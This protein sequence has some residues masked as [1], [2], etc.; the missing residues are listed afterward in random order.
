MFNKQN[1]F[2]STQK[3]INI[4]FK[5]SLITLFLLVFSLTAMTQTR[6]ITGVVIDKEE[7]LPLIGV[8]VLEQGTGRGTL[9]DFDGSYTIELE[10][11][12]A[13]LNF[14][15]TG[16]KE[17]KIIVTDQS[18]IDIVMSTDV[19]LLEEVVVIGYGTVKKSDL[20]GAV[21]KVT[22]ED[23]N[24]GVLSSPDQLIQGRA[25]GVQVIS[26]SGQPGG[27]NTVRIRGNNSIRTGNDPLYVVDG[28]QITATSGKPGASNFGISSSPPSNPLSYLNPSDIA[29]VEI[30]KDASATAIYGSRGANGVIIITT[31]RGKAGQPT[32]EVNSSLGMSKLLNEPDHLNASEYREA[33]IAYD[34]PQGDFGAEIDPI[35]A[36]TRDAAIT[37]NHSISFGNATDKGSFRVSLGYFDQEGIIKNSSLNRMNANIS[38]SY[39]FLQSEKLG[40]DVNLV[41]SNIREETPPIGQT[42]G[43]GGSLISAALAWNPTLDF[44]DENGSIFQLG[45]GQLA[46]PIALLEGFADNSKQTNIISKVSPSY[47]ITNDLTYR[48]DYAIN[49][50]NGSRRGYGQRWVN[51]GDNKGRGFAYVNTLDQTTTILTHTLNYNKDISEQL[52]INVLGGFEWQ[53]SV[54]EFNNLSARDFP[55]DDADYTGYIA[56]TPITSRAASSGISPTEELQSF[57]GRANFNFK[58][59]YLLTATFRAD[60]S[61]KF[62]ENN[63]YGYFPSA[64][65]AWNLSN[66]QF[67]ENTLFSNLKLRLSWGQTGNQSFPA[68]AAGERWRLANDGNG[69]ALQ[70]AANPFLKWE[71]TTSTNIGVDVGVLEDRI[72][73]SVEYFNNNTADLLFETQ[74]IFPGPEDS[75]V[76][77]NL[78]DATVINKGVEVTLDANIVSKRRFSWNIGANASF[79]DNIFEDFEGNLDYGQLYGQGISGTFSQ[80]LEAGQPLNSFY[81][82]VYLGTNEEGVDLFKTDENDVPV[83]EFV[84]DANP[85]VIL[86]FTSSMDFGKLSLNLNFNGIFGNQILY[87]TGMTVTNITNV[88]FYNIATSQNGSNL[89]NGPRASS[90]YLY[91]GDYLRLS[92]AS[93]VY[94]LGNVRGFK[95]IQFYLTGT[96]LLTFTN[97]IGSDPEVNTVNSVNGLSSSGIEYEAYPSSKTLVF[98][99]KFSL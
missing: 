87:N 54:F 36:I 95:N 53:K 72:S 86:G 69:I 42:S 15:Y 82:P 65:F 68:G 9:T 13:V 46:S 16:Y 88:G 23:F 2:L 83:K 18:T 57:F 29:S 77:I 66:E 47:R 33:L 39:Q 59:R 38:G 58:N 32:L 70:N 1:K 64:A 91:D 43:A 80:R 30:L 61:N 94:N 4:Y 99:T 92:N 24:G 6:K 12:E 79:I 81:L 14:S 63:K 73:A 90:K 28:I 78:S 41:V 48:M 74:V 11:S 31:K 45:N 71:T 62:G 85:D 22:E 67:M 35:D 3:G 40:L 97:Y 8:T 25:A 56:S 51:S 76:W 37:N 89:A 34:R 60:G 27:A 21:S 17:E 44:Y 84:G 5:G 50:I 96:N 19:S 98:G 10:G 20:T 26:S 75:R 55:L 49:S 52:T 7:R 93:L